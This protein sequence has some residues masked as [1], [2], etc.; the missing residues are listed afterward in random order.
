MPTR[1]GTRPPE[2]KVRAIAAFAAGGGVLEA[3][4][5]AGVDRTTIW[6]WSREDAQFA[7]MRDASVAAVLE[8]AQ[9]DLR[10]LAGL[11]VDALA[12]GLKATVKQ[13]VVK[14]K[15]GAYEVVDLR[16]DS[17]AVHT[18]DIVSQRLP[19]MSPRS[20]LAVDLSGSEQ[21]ARLIRA[22]DERLQDQ[23]PG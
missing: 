18:A 11:V 3:A 12:R 13:T 15:K 6:R 22:A 20:A 2:A 21:L 19:G 23:P 10:G 14:L 1:K 4:D 5:A 7:S 9:S 8:Q 16:D 17:L